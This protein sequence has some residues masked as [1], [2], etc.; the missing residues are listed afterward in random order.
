[1]KK[2]LIILAAGMLW[3]NFVFAE[4]VKLPDGTTVNS[5][6]QDGYKLFSTDSIRSSRDVTGILYTLTKDREVVSCGFNFGTAKTL[7][8]KP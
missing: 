2:F 6:L 7:C 5:L 1:M 8:I 4:D 3:C